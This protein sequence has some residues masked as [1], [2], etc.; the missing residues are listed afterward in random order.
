[1]YASPNPKVSIIMPAYNAKATIESS[2]SSVLAQTLQDWELIVVDDCS[3]DTTAAIADSFAAQDPRIRL[4]KNP[5]NKGVAGTRNK[6]LSH[7]K[8]RWI[9]FLDSDDLWRNDKLE[10]QLPFAEESGAKITY[11]GTAFMD[12]AG[13]MFSYYQP[14]V[15]LF[16]YKALRRQNIMSCSSVMVRRDVMAPFPQGFMHEDYALWLQ[17]LRKIG[18][19]HGLN[20]PLLIYRV[21]KQSVSSNRL[22]SARMVFYTYRHTGYSPAIAA[23]LTLR[24]AI[25]SISKRA[26]L[27]FSRRFSGIPPRSR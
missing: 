15:P 23:M 2:I 21:Q 3:T 12:P 17:L 10:Q 20:E 22:R 24:Y 19:A 6:A 11:T 18:P 8:G 1:M 16:S 26:K 5:H 4:Y 25:H 13:N 14:A 7:A 9:A 27:K